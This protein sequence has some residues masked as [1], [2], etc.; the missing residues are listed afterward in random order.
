MKEGSPLTKDHR[1]K[2]AKSCKRSGPDS[3]KKGL[4]LCKG[5]KINN[6]NACKRIAQLD[7]EGHFIRW[8]ESASAAAI[9]VNRA[10]CSISLCALGFVKQS[11]GFKWKYE[12]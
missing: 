3:C 7:M 12:E 2:I 9:G 1:E 11:A 5:K 10:T 8:W 6:K 4:N